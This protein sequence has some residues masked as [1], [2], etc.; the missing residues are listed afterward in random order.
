M[1]AFGAT[2]SFT[3][4]VEKIPDFIRTEPTTNYIARLD[5][6]YT[7]TYYSILD[8]FGSCTN[9]IKY[10]ERGAGAPGANDAPLDPARGV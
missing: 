4:N 10:N 2:L 9:T 1:A 7:N 3:N 6:S 5:T 8:C